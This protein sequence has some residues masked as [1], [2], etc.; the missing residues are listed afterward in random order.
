[1]SWLSA[2]EAVPLEGAL[3][4]LLSLSILNL[5]NANQ[6]VSIWQFDGIPLGVLELCY[7]CL[8]TLSSLLKTSSVAQVH[9]DWGVV[10]ASRGVRRVVA[11]EAVLIIPLLSLFWDESSHL[12]IVLSPEDLI[13]GFLGYDAVDGSLFQDLVV[14]ARRWFEDILSYTRD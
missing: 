2:I 3:L 13:D 9:R 14:V 4:L 10:K 5:G 11:L 1:M 8:C 7:A 12:I 6:L